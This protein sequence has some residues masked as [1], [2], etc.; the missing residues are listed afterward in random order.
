ME[1]ARGKFGPIDILVANHAI[2][3]SSDIDL[4]DMSTEQ[5][6]KT[7]SINLT[8][9]FLFTKYF[10]QNLKT[11]ME[12]GTQA[13]REKKVTTYRPALVV[14]GSTSGKFGERGHVD[15]SCSKSALIYGFTRT[16]SKNS[17]SFKTPKTKTQSI[18]ENEI[19]KL[20]PLGR[21][22]AVS[23]GWIRTPLAE[24]NIKRGDHFQALLTTPLKKIANCDGDSLPFFCR[25]F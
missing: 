15:Y 4:I 12:S 3:P 16:M 7:L 21:A 11:F 13:E 5:F 14:I 10:F 19:V 9:V 2:F 22:N 18:Q 20:A 8:G 23:P 6:E 24:E 1:E 25:F 17:L